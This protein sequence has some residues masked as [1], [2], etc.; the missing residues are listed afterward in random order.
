MAFSTR[1]Q[2]G[3]TTWRVARFD[4]RSVWNG[5]FRTPGAFE[6]DRHSEPR[7]MFVVPDSQL[8]FWTE[9]WQRG[10]RESLAE[11][12]RGEAVRFDD[13]AEAARWLL[14]E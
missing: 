5:V 10:E 13:P 8:Y 14:A 9:S 4:A 3:G 6:D 11:I 2:C 7:R 12:E 1:Q